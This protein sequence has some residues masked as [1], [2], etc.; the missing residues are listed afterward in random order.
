MNK[1]ILIVANGF[2]PENSPRSFRATELAKELVRQGHAVKVIT[3]SR[4]GT[5]IYCQE[6][7]IEFKDLG[8]LTWPVPTIKGSG[9]VRLF[10]RV[11][12]RFS[13]LLFEY[14]MIQLIPLVKKALKN[15]SGYDMLISIAVPYPIHW[16]V[17]Q[18]RNKKHTIA[19]IWVADCG[20]PYMLQENDTFKPPFYFGWFERKF[21]R[22]ADFI[23]VPTANSING[24][25]K[26]FH[27][28]IR[29]ISQGFRFDD[30]TLFHGN[31]ESGKV[32]FGYGG[33]FIP[34]RRDPSE[35]L[36]FLNS[37]D[38]TFDFEFHIYTST[39]QF[40]EQYIEASKG[41]IKLKRVTDRAALLFEMSKMDFVVN[42]ENVGTAQTPSKLIDY[43]IIKKPILSVKFS[44]FKSQI[45]MEFLKGDYSNALIINDPDQYRIENVARKF[46]NLLEVNH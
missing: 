3:H 1:K 4:P 17:A 29:V 11:I 20:D 30:L 33:M 13:G 5:A 43:V 9:I 32:I 37:L 10:W 38:S 22:K 44:D 14:P 6:N 31:K 2:Y 39:P 46:L 41:R 8:Q 26:E 18:V 42:F 15:E 35:L 40:V 24:Y 34:N 21:C 28:K 19:K 25:Y 27:D 7:G 16:G 23:T 36:T 45:V 12:V